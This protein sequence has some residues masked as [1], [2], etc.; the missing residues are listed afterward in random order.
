MRLTTRKVDA[1]TQAEEE[2]L[3]LVA[4]EGTSW[5]LPGLASVKRVALNDLQRLGYVVP[6]RSG[7]PPD[8]PG[9]SHGYRITDE[10]REAIAELARR[11][12]S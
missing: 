10:G 1:F 6:T 5:F 3:A 2:M 9:G 8:A 4:S 12:G 11:K 7:R